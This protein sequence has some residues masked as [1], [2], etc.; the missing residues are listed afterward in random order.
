MS[1][2][3]NLHYGGGAVGFPNDPAFELEY[4]PFGV[5]S[6]LCMGV[7]T[8]ACQGTKVSLAAVWRYSKT[9]WIVDALDTILG[10]GGLRRR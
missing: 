3:V 8:T 4:A 5:G 6:G 10:A 1:A 7:V 2:A 9:V